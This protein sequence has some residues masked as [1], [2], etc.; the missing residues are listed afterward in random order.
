MSFFPRPSAWAVSGRPFG[1]LDMVS[2]YP[3]QTH[4]PL[5]RHA[6]LAPVRM[7]VATLPRAVW[8][9][10]AQASGWMAP[11]IFRA[12]RRTVEDNLIRLLTNSLR[13]P[14]G[15]SPYP[16]CP[17]PRRRVPFA[18]RTGEGN[19]EMHPPL[20]HPSAARTEE[21]NGETHPPL[22]SRDALVRRTFGNFATFLGDSFCL[23][24]VTPGALD[25]FF[26]RLDGEANLRQALAAGRG[27]ILVTPHLG[28]WELGGHALAL[29][30]FPVT[31]LSLRVAD[32]A[33]NRVREEARR[34][35]GIETLYVEESA[36]S[37]AGYLA[38]M[39]GVLTRGRV[40]C[41]LADRTT[42]ERPV[43]VRFAGHPALFPPGGPLLSLLTGAPI[44]AAFVVRERGLR[45]RAWLTPPFA[46][47]DN[48]APRDERVA[49][50]CQ[51]IADAFAQVIAAHPDQWYN[52]FPPWA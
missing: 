15:P 25:V 43:P 38:A 5:H 51:Q 40:L 19:N 31:V 39:R 41:M 28:L 2:R 8:H 12:A 1:A 13:T 45:Y 48:A 21:G 35:N 9:P 22:V 34:R 26:S 29:A 27:A 3:Q 11:M 17:E 36:G 6:L 30:G 49:D 37:P 14:A 33:M 32:D 46:P 16:P 52:F 18:T 50:L 47:K 7:L 23:G 20:F 10:I 42:S 4:N 24:R 44:L